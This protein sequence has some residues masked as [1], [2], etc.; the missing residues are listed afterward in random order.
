MAR[1]AQLSGARQV[2]SANESAT[3]FPATLGNQASKSAGLLNDGIA[4]TSPS[5][6]PSVPG[7]QA[8]IVP[9]SVRLR[10][11]TRSICVY[12]RSQPRHVPY[13]SAWTETSQ[14]SYIDTAQS[15]AA[16]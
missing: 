2:G 1:D 11:A 16:R 12:P 8:S 10:G 4:T 13:S 9:L 6:G 7:L 15:I 5:T 3:N 14:L